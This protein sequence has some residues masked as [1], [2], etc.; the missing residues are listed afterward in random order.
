MDLSFVSLDP[1]SMQAIIQVMGVAITA[2]MAIIG[3][4]ITYFLGRKRNNAEIEKLKLKSAA[5]KHEKARKN[6]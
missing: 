4:A 2:M 6:F 1:A 3:S 5:K